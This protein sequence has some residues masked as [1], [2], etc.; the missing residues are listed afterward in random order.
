M[1]ENSFEWYICLFIFYTF[2]INYATFM[3]QILI[4]G[5]NRIQKTIIP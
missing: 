4:F 2:P 1:V 5:L 3:D